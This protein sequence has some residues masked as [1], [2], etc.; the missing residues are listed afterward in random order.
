MLDRY[1]QVLYF[2][3][4]GLFVGLLLLEVLAQLVLLRVEF[5]DSDFKL[6][7]APF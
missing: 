7:D 6:N 2:S 5:S 3:I 1:V 4:Q